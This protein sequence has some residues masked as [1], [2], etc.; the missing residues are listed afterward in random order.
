MSYYAEMFKTVP[1]VQKVFSKHKVCELLKRSARGT[2]CHG[3][4]SSCFAPGGGS[5]I[6]PVQSG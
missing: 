5:S 6:D 3:K 2:R 1:G 4:L